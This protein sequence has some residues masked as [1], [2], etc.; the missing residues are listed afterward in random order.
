[1]EKVLGEIRYPTTG[2]FPVD[3]LPVLSSTLLR[4]SP[5]ANRHGGAYQ[6]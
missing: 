1:M 2:C 3:L 4:Q 6:G 5:D